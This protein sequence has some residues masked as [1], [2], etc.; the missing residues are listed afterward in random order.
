MLAWKEIILTTL[1]LDVDDQATEAIRSIYYRYLR[2][3]E[4]YYSG[5]TDFSGLPGT[6]T[7]DTSDTSTNTAPPK[8]KHKRRKV[9]T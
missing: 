1:K 7:S 5:V 8:N 2:D 4:A 3:Y 6:S 9:G